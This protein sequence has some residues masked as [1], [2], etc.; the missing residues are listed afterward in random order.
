MVFD[1][2]NWLEPVL[3]FQGATPQNDTDSGINSQGGA[4]HS[5]ESQSKG[6]QVNSQGDRSAP[7]WILGF[8]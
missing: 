5:K 2:K 7:P 1:A 8:A 6:F 3:W 4:D